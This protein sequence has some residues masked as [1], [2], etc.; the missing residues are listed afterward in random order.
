MEGGMEGGRANP[1]EDIIAALWGTA[2]PEVPTPPELPERIF[3]FGVKE[4][5]EEDGGRDVRGEGEEV[6]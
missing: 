5:E 4:E 3:A 6:V 1:P 2:S